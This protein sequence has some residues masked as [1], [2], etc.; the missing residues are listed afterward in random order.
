[1]TMV[2]DTP[3]EV[4]AFEACPCDRCALRKRCAAEHLACAAYSMFFAGRPQSCWLP[5]PRTPS[6]DT[7]DAILAMGPKP[8]ALNWT[9]L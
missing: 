5:A 1:M 8:F 9:V 7:F 4:A 3:A 6:R 2:A